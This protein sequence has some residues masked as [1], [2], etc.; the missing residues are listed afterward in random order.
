MLQESGEVPEPGRAIEE[1]RWFCGTDWLALTVYM[2]F[3]TLIFALQA[4]SLGG[5]SLDY[6]SYQ[7]AP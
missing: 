2:H 1:L 7:Q 5:V 4:E 3:L 6:A